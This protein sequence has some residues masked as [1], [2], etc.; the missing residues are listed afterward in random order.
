[1]VTIG[2]NAFKIYMFTNYLS[3]LDQ[4]TLLGILEESLEI[5]SLIEMAQDVWELPFEL[6][7]GKIELVDAEA[8]LLKHSEPKDEECF[9][10][11]DLIDDSG[12]IDD[13]DWEGEEDYQI[14]SYDD[15]DDEYAPYDEFDDN[16]EEIEE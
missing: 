7:E 10:C 6:S 3:K 12:L 2:E 14:V 1:M 15:E 11:P 4:N 5:K 8:L 16:L 9:D 13:P